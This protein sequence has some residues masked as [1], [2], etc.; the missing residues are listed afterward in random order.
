M[1]DTAI[2]MDNTEIKMAM[3]RFQ[4]L[5]EVLTVLESDYSYSTGVLVII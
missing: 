3:G 5:M 4:F 2:E 1:A